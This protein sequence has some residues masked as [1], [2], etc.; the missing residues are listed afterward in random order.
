MVTFYP[1]TDAGTGFCGKILSLEVDTHTT[2]LRVNINVSLV[3][4][5]LRPTKFELLS[6]LGKN[7]HNKLRKAICFIF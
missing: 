7:S 2:T 3:A 5:V 6:D 1:C 4:F